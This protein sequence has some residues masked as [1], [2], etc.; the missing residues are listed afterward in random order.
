MPSS[1]RRPV[2]VALDVIIEADV[3]TVFNAITQWAEQGR[4][5]V[6]T[7]VEVREGDGRSLGS[8]VAAWTGAGPVGFWDT[9]TITRW[10][11]PY[12]VDVLH[13]GSVVRGTG[14]MEVVALPQ[15]RSRFVWSEDLD[16]PLGAL[17]RLGWPLARPA[18]LAGVQRSLD[19]FARL[20]ESGDL[21]A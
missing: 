14:T 15:G 2:R 13:T 4:W 1:E 11:E 16:L 18:F 3:Q 7:R 9:M 19:A 21:P 20:V 17:G 5:M 10:D 12:R 6:G 8:Q